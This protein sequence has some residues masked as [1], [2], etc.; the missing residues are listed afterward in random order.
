MSLLFGPRA[1]ACQHSRVPRR[2]A[3]TKREVRPNVTG[4]SDCGTFAI[5]AGQC[6]IARS[7]REHRQ[8]K[9]CSLTLH[10]LRRTRI[11]ILKYSLLDCAIVVVLA[12]ARPGTQAQALP[13]TI[14][15]GT[16][17]IYIHT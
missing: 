7:S 5:R 14:S 15:P 3:F 17:T 6:A 11:H 2:S 12:L 10:S 13:T 4:V 8:K 1:E 9:I 16:T